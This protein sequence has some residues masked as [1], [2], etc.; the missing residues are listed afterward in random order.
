MFQ[1]ECEWSIQGRGT[2]Y[3]NRHILH[4]DCCPQEIPSCFSIS[5]KL[6]SAS[7]AF[8]VI[9]LSTF[10]FPFHLSLYTFHLLPLTWFSSLIINYNVVLDMW[11]FSS[12]PYPSFCSDTRNL[13]FDI[14]HVKALTYETSCPSPPCSPSFLFIQILYRFTTLFLLWSFQL[15]HLPLTCVWW[16][17]LF[18]H[19]IVV[20]FLPCFLH[21]SPIN[22]LTVFLCPLIFCM[23]SLICSCGADVENSC[24]LV[25]T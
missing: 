4:P 19:H 11:L 18:S 17:R 1:T 16:C 12:P 23:P 13:Y 10:L 6:I 2:S 9:R 14:W 21:W 25:R 3:H 22:S 20:Y 24:F 7:S 15:H 5:F 8:P